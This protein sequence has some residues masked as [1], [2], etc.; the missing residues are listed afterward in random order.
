ISH[1]LKFEGIYSGRIGHIGRRGAGY[2]GHP[3]YRLSTLV[4]NVGSICYRKYDCSRT[5]GTSQWYSPLCWRLATVSSIKFHESRNR[6]ENTISSIGRWFQK[7]L[8]I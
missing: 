5:I 1:S 2:L 6:Q 3:S 7:R 8:C 4:Q